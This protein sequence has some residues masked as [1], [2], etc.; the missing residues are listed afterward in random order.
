M[1]VVIAD[2][3]SGAAELAG[4]G[5]RYGINVEMCTVV[6]DADVEL[7]VV[8]TDS[9]SM[10]EEDAIKEAE[11]VASAVMLLN[12]EMVYKK[13]DSVF[14]GHV[15]AELETQLKIF[16]LK[17]A[18][19]VAANPSLG[20]TI[21]DGIFYYNDKPIHKSSFSNDPEFAITSSNVMEM[22]RVENDSATLIKKGDKFGRKRIMIGEVKSNEDL[23][24]WAR[25]INK[26]I[27]PAGASGFFSAILDSKFSR[28][29][30]KEQISSPIS[31]PAL[32]ICGST[33]NKSRTAIKKISRR[34]GPVSYMP[35]AVARE[36]DFDIE[37]Y[38]LWCNE[39]ISFIHLEGRAI[40]S[41]DPAIMKGIRVSARELRE[42]TAMA[43]KEVCKQLNIQEFFI[44]GGATAASVIRQLEFKTFIP[45]EE[46][47][48]GVVRMRVK[49]KPGVCITVKPGSYDWPPNAWD[50]K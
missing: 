44:E 4:I 23:T 5:L 36:K 21:V 18:L 39:I 45:T 29:N 32:F 49:E 26:N 47:A 38:Q 40:I 24:E 19:V 3:L 8:A 31:S 37:I 10:K 43:V 30:T 1:I 6:G 34:G 2:D 11:R 27:L 20:R 16:N 35:A 41:I 25:R 28:V 48:P 15:L 14:R 46:L 12:P 33:F 22:L 42:K 50:F 9:R 7:L 17:K 13:I